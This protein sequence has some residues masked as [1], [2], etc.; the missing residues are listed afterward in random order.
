MLRLL[1][2]AVRLFFMGLALWLPFLLA[3]FFLIF[4]LP[5]AL[6]NWGILIGFAKYAGYS[7]LGYFRSLIVTLCGAG[8]GLLLFIVLI[9]ILVGLDW[10]FEL[11]G[12]G[13][14]NGFVD[15]Y[16]VFPSFKFFLLSGTSWSMAN[17][18]IIRFS[19]IKDELVS[20]RFA[21]LSALAFAPLSVVATSAFFSAIAGW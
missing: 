15:E 16:F 20:W 14:G 1:K 21:L 8:F 6:L 2:W 7:T 18:T 11:S 4:Y 9:L 17:L 3:I 12:Q 13:N 10:L 19:L 5:T